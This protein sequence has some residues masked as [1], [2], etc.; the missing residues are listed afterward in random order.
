[1]ISL[2]EGLGAGYPG[3]EQASLCRWNGTLGHD[4]GQVTTGEFISVEEQLKLAYKDGKNCNGKGPKCSLLTAENVSF[5]L[6]VNLNLLF[7][8]FVLNCK[9]QNI[10]EYYYVI[11]NA[12]HNGQNN[13][14]QILK[15]SSDGICDLVQ[16]LYILNQKSIV[17]SVAL[18]CLLI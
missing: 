2:C 9:L 7:C 8:C 18:F 11:M 15:L 5:Y 1:M 6:S 16:I 4:Y 14:N 3:C 13:E 12:I 17:I 10:C